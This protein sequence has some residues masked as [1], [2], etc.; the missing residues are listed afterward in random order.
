MSVS[1]TLLLL[2]SARESL[3]ED[4]RVWLRGQAPGLTQVGVHDPGAVLSRLRGRLGDHWLPDLHTV[5]ALGRAGVPVH[6][7]YLRRCLVCEA[8]VPTVFGQVDQ[9]RGGTGFQTFGHYGSTAFDP[10]DGTQLS[11]VVCDPCLVDRAD[12]LVQLDPDSDT[13]TD[14]SPDEEARDWVAA[15]AMPELVGQ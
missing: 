1:A 13:F 11:A 6:N 3:D 4:G 10:Q 7:E 15:Q 9:P 2:L 8:W 5:A 14:W 12:R